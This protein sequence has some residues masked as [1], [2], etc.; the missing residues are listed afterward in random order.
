MA[1]SKEAMESAIKE[2]EN[3]TISIRGAARKY[4]ISSSTLHDHVTGKYSKVGAGGPTV[5]TYTEEREIALSLIT[6]GEI[7]FGLTKEIANVV[8]SDYLKEN[9]IPNPFHNGIPGR[10]WWERFKKR[11]PCISERQ[12]QLLCKKRL[13]ASH[14]SIIN[15]WFDNLKCVFEKSGLS[16]TNQSSY[17]LQRIW[18]CDETGLSTT[19]SSKFLLVRRGSKQVSEVSSG[20]GREYITVLT[21]GSASGELLPPFIL[22]KGKNLYQRWT[23]NGLAGACYGISESGWMDGI[24]FLSW[25]K[26]QFIPAVRHL[27]ASGPVF[28]IFDG[29]YSHISLDLIKTARASNIQLICLPPNTTHLLQPLDVGLFSVLK[30]KWRNILK[31]IS[32]KQ[33]VAKLQRKPFPFLYPNYGLT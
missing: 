7:G 3:K 1:Y 20:S 27:T 19:V 17:E 18:N 32:M 28:L 29:H 8:I 14:S 23:S 2:V 31:V 5:L 6:L 15:A 11:W 30:K 25:F 4:G 24:N 13:T 26:N 12:P 22:Y 21:A 9:K 10:D 16:V 33:K